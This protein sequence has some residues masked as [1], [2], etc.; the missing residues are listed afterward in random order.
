[1]CARIARFSFHGALGGPN[2][3]VMFVELKMRERQLY[4]GQR[5]RW[6][7]SGCLDE[8]G[9]CPVGVV[10]L[11]RVARLANKSVDGGI[12]VAFVEFRFD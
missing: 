7:D 8:Q 10:I 12:T 5:V 1:M 4:E 3:F 2:G 9:L 11:E 6:T